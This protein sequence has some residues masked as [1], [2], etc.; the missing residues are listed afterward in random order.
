MNSV[1]DF[2]LHLWRLVGTAAEK[3]FE[4]I[5]HGS[6]VAIKIRAKARVLNMSARLIVDRPEGALCERGVN[7][8]D[9]NFP[10]RNNNTVASQFRMVALASVDDK[11]KFG[12]D[13]FNLIA[14]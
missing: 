5:R 11:A 3:V 13:L 4:F 7:R 9:Q 12:E 2:P 1:H 8:D 10:S 6:L 14:R